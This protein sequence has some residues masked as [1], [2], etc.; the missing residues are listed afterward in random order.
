MNSR[1][2]VCMFVGYPKGTRGGLFYSPQDRKVIVSTHFTSLEED[3]MNNFKPKSKVIL[4]ELSSDQVDAQLSTPV[5][6]HEEQQQP[7][8]QH[9]IIPKQPSLGYLR[10]TS[11]WHKLIR[12]SQMNMYKIPLATTKL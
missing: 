4:E 3:Y 5:I 10:D 9:R 2:E 12:L 11:Y 6:E 7:A 8:D 1:S